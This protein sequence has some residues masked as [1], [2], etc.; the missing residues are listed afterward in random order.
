MVL[1][2]NPPRQEPPGYYPPGPLSPRTTSPGQHPPM[3]NIPWKNTYPHFSLK[4]VKYNRIE[5]QCL[6]KKICKI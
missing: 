1:G 6:S 3:D 5:K 2:Q 4:S